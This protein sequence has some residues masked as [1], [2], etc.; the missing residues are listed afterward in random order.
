M[1]S[2]IHIYN[3]SSKLGQKGF[4]KRLPGNKLTRKQDFI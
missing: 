2:I 4:G 3:K 1:A